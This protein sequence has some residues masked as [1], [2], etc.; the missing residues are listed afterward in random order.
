MSNLYA[1]GWRQGSVANHELPAT[2][3][4]I[5]GDDLR[6]IRQT[7]SSWMVCTQDC[8]LSK[9]DLDADEPLIELRPILPEERFI[10]WGIRSRHFKVAEGRCLDANAPR[11]LVTPSFLHNVA[12]SR[13]GVLDEQRRRFLK[14][15]LGFRYDRPAVPEHLLPL[16]LEV[17]DRCSKRSGRQVSDKVHDILMQFDDSQEPVRVVLFGVVNASEDIEEVRVWLAEV[18][19]RIDEER[20]VLSDVM[21]A[22]RS[23]TPLQVVEESY[24]ADVSQLTWSRRK[25]ESS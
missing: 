16:A 4:T 3:F 2:H 13:E 1:D 11:C 8:D 17:A 14:T 21:V 18:G 9:A 19:H 15:W 7:V 22:T 20:G 6:E 10:D 23:D 5:D 25:P 12:S 24:S